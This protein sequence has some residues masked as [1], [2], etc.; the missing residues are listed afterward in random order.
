MKNM[1][2]SLLADTI[3]IIGGADGPTAVFIATKPSDLE[4]ALTLAWQGMTGIFLVML[5]I[6]LL[7]W[8]LSRLSAGKKTK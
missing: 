4:K 2:T 1:M 7:V 5:L 3:G 6:A 8:A